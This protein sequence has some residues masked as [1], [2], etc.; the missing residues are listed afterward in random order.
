MSAVQIH[1][2]GIIVAFVLGMSFS[3]GTF[4]MASFLINELSSINFSI[5]FWL[6]RT[7]RWQLQHLFDWFNVCMYACVC[8]CVCMNVCMY[9]VILSQASSD[10]KQTQCY[11]INGLLFAVTFFVFRV[12]FN[13]VFVLH[14]FGYGIRRMM[15]GDHT[16]IP[17]TFDSLAPL[18]H[19]DM[20]VMC[21]ER[22]THFP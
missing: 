12:C 14:L 2:V 4:Y 22:E 20:S 9:G 8:V 17:L 6:V 21:G 5:N 13:F 10:Q 3:I 11:A 16:H 7:T 18:T 1:H 19:A 15:V